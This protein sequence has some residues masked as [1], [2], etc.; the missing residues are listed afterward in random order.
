MRKVCFQ[1]VLLIIGGL[2][3]SGAS[4]AQDGHPVT[5]SK[6]HFPYAFGNFVWWSD[7]DLRAELKRHLPTL[8]EE[9]GRGSPIESR[10]QT[11]LI[12]LL[13]EKGIQAEVQ[14]IERRHG[15]LHAIDA[16]REALRHIDEI[17]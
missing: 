3:T 6:D 10:V 1:L 11:V 12:Q 9:I 17:D 4:R 5:N 13:R 15:L 2:S 7:S 14:A 8:G 16:Q